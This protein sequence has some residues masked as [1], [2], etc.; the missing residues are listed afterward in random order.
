MPGGF[1]T[2]DEL[3]EILILVQ[4]DKTRKIPNHTGLSTFLGRSD[5]VVEES[6][7]KDKTI[8]PDDINLMPDI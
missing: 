2:L 3:A 5:T 1:G 4:T 7:I 6:L 8:Q